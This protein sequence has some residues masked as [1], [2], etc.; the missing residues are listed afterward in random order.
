MPKLFSAPLL[1]L[2]P[3]FAAII[4]ALSGCGP[5]IS[6]TELVG[7]WRISRDSQ[8]FFPADFDVSAATLALKSDHTFVANG[9]P[10]ELV[11]LTPSGPDAA[12]R[13]NGSGRWALLG[14]QGFSSAQG[15]MLEFTSV[16]GPG[17]YRIPFGSMIFSVDRTAGAPRIFYFHDD[18]DLGRR[19]NF[20]ILSSTN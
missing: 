15:F 7:T 8:H 19:I 2:I 17:T 14:R 3:F 12:T 13:I 5:N 11:L 6:P 10:Q 9:L 18:P 16:Q 1:T 20:E 4:A